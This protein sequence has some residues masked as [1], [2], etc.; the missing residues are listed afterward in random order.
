MPRTKDQSLQEVF[1]KAEKALSEVKDSRLVTRLLA[2]RGY[3]KHKAK[4][5]AEIFNT[6]TRTIY[7][8]VE[9]FKLHGV[10][11]LKDKPKGHPHPILNQEHHEQIASWLEAGKTPDG[12]EINWTL[13]SLCLYIKKEFG[14][15]IKK[16]ALSNTLKKLR[17]SVRKPR[18][19]HAN[20]SEDQRS[21]FKKNS[22]PNQGKR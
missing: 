21:D 14:L 19:T 1:L 6:Q 4:D 18:P 11:G 2:I 8:W 16:S 7:K 9:L 12:K 20:S 3:E 22:R 17:Y 15:E 5:L 10:E 13:N